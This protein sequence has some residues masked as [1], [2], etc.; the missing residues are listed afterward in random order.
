MSAERKVFGRLRGMASPMP[1][2]IDI[3][4]KSYQDFLQPD[5]EPQKRK[6]KGLQAIFHEIFPVASYDGRYVLDFVSYR[7][8][9]PKYPLAEALGDGHT[10]TL[11]SLRRLFCVFAATVPKI[12]GPTSSSSPRS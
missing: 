4:T 2:L 8:G 7:F 1:D 9:E 3:Q 6:N 12:T 10:L 5:V 11:P